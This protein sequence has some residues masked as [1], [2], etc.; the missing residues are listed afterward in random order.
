MKGVLNKQVRRFCDVSA[1]GVK[2]R[3]VLFLI[4]PTKVSSGYRQT[5]SYQSQG[6]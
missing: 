3:K 4:A 5:F 2:W 6:K 1:V